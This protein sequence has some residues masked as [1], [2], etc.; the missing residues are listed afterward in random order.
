MN[1]NII[2]I[3]CSFEESIGC[4]RD[5]KRCKFDNGNVDLRKLKIKTGYEE[6]AYIAISNLKNCY[7]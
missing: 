1:K 5:C 6:M 2:D 7:V 3:Y 4:K